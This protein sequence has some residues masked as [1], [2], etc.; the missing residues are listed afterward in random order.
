MN[1]RSIARATTAAGVVV[2]LAACAAETDS[3]SSSDESSTGDNE[4]VSVTFDPDAKTLIPEMPVDEWCG[5]DVDEP[6]KVGYADGVEFGVWRQMA[7]KTLETQAAL[8][9]A[10]DPDIIHVSANGDQQKAVADINGLVAQGVDLI[11]TNDD[12]GDAMLPA[13]KS[14][15]DAGVKV[16]TYA[17]PH[18][19]VPGVDVT[20]ASHEDAVGVG[21]EL[22]K[23]LIEAIGGEGTV[24]FLGGPAGAPL[25]VDQYKGFQEAMADYPDVKLIP[26]Q[27]AVTN[28][29]LP[30]AQKVTAALIAQNPEIDGVFA[31]YGATGLG[32]INA[33][34]AAGQPVPPL[35][36][37]AT[38]NDLR[39]LWVEKS[40]GPD[41]FELITADSTLSMPLA[42]SQQ[43]IAA[44]TGGTYNPLQHILLPIVYNTLEDRNPECDPSLPAD[45]DFTG[46]LS[47]DE[48]L[49]VLNQ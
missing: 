34:E 18:G 38:G 4:A 19:G 8:C 30:E 22:G 10:V 13:Y 6:I 28:W 40:K 12:F 23:A 32:A 31:D 14:A 37:V 45:A 49:E 21:R 16:V 48:V 20:A 41:R 36:A 11:V 42:G 29:S 46:P 24:L 1:R 9:P 33:F 15:V 25:S 5:D 7:Y 44:A 26:D 43:G 39:C 47:R 17:S 2:L 35:A 27:P 3:G